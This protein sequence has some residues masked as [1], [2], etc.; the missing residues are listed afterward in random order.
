MVNQ[1]PTI[2]ID[3]KTWYIDARLSQIRNVENPHEWS[4]ESPDLISFLIENKLTD[5]DSNE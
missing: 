5:L 1:L 3:G 4:D 2:K